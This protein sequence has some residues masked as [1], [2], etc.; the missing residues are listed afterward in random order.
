MKRVKQNMQKSIYFNVREMGR[1]GIEVGLWKD[2][3]NRN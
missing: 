1:D 3:K 2:E